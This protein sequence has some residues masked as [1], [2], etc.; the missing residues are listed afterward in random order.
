MGSTCSSCAFDLRAGAGPVDPYG[1]VYPDV[2]GSPNQGLDVDADPAGTVHYRGRG[3]RD[4]DGNFFL[5]GHVV[6]DRLVMRAPD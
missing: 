5:E 3:S 2:A 6:T 4:R 1:A